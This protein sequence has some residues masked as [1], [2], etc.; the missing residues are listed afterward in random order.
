MKIYK[1]FKDCPLTTVYIGRSIDWADDS[2]NYEYYYPFTTVKTAIFNGT[3]A[4]DY[5]FSNNLTTA[6]IGNYCQELSFSSKN[7][8]NLYIF[9]N[10]I[11][12]V[13]LTST[14]T[15]VFV[16]NKNDIPNK[17]SDLSYQ[18]INNLVD[19]KNLQNGASYIYG[20][21]PQN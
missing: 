18:S 2:Y 10:D 16:I 17:I 3:K 5:G 11:T 6:Y 8:S 21:T 1:Y 19:I 15:D 14:K 9:T 7:L 20:N 12:R 13:Y 4:S